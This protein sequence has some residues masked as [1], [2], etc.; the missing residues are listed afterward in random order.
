M[1]TIT[2]IYRK[3]FQHVILQEELHQELKDVLARDAVNSYQKHQKFNTLTKRIR[4][5]VKDNVDTGLTDDK[6]KK[7]S[8]RAVMFHSEPTKVKIDGIETSMPTVSKIAFSGQ[9]DKHLPADH[10]LLGEAQNNHE[11]EVAKH[12]GV[13]EKIGD[14]E[15][16]T[17]EGHPFMPPV[18]DGHDNGSWLHVAKIDPLDAKSMR[19]ATKTAEFPK[20][21]SHT[22]LVDAVTHHFKEAHGESSWSKHPK[23][24]LENLMEHPLVESAFNMCMDTDTIPSDFGKRNLG[25]WNHPVTGRKYVVASDAGFSRNVMRAYSKAR[26]NMRNAYR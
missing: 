7:G 9:L 20:G 14:N 1:K 3:E 13:L 25:I 6:P 22:E 16:R 11:H 21:I 18:L 26:Q 12:Y 17:R 19:E 4:S 10:E 15:Y 24:H 8:S 5:M 23:E 2:D